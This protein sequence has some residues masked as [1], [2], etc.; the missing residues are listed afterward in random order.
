MMGTPLARDRLFDDAAISNPHA[1][2]GT[3][4]AILMSPVV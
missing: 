3:P 2:I 1:R 4:A